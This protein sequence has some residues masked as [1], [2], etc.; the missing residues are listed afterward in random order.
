ML[1][2]I[3]QNLFICLA[4][5]SLPYSANI[6]FASSYFFLRFSFNP[7]ARFGS[8]LFARSA[9]FTCFAKGF[10]FTRRRYDSYSSSSGFVKSCTASTMCFGIPFSS[11][12]SA[13]TSVS[14]IA[15]CRTAMVLS[16][17]ELRSPATASGC[18]IYATPFLSICPLCAFTAISNAVSKTEFIQYI[19]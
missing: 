7:L 3:L 10:S 1:L 12:Y 2:A 19:L 18:K 8:V 16:S 11:K 5:I 13:V 14:S 15:S 9:S 17:N 4:K 6:L